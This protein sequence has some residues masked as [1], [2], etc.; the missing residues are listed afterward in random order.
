MDQQH[1]S[2]GQHHLKAA[3]RV[4]LP[5]HL[6]HFYCHVLDARL[7]DAGRKRMHLRRPCGLDVPGEGALQHNVG[8]A[9]CKDAAVEA[10]LQLR[11]GGA[12]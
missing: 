11:Q 5:L 6:L 9:D 12:M 10:L 3:A 1:P 2:P 7:L 4:P 8:A